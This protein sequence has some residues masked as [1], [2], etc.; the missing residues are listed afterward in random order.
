MAVKKMSN[1]EISELRKK[2]LV[3]EWDK[4]RSQI[5]FAK[6]MQLEEMK[7]QLKEL[8]A[9]IETE[10]KNLSEGVETK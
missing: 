3:L 7:K 4:K 5:N 10:N 8:E 2:I 1:E 9:G 6:N